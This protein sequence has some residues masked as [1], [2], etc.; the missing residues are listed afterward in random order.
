M[1]ALADILWF[2]QYEVAAMPISQFLDGL[3]FEPEVRRGM[4][5]AFERSCAALALKDRSDPLVAIVAQTIIELAKRGE[6]NPDLLCERALDAFSRPPPRQDLRAYLFK[7]RKG[8]EIED[9]GSIG[10]A[11]DDEAVAIA[12]QVVLD[13]L[14]DEDARR[15]SDWALEIVEGGRTVG[16]LA[17]DER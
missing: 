9:L 7:L 4:G 2:R 3:E 10:L 6:R 13:H 12:R 14:K 1:I 17:F 16:T 8:S 5:A 11:H 15:Y